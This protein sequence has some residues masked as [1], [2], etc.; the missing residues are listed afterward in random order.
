MLQMSQRDR[1]RLVVVR[2]VAMKQIAVTRGAELLRLSRKQMGRLRDRYVEEGDG[3]V[4]HR[5][6]GRRSNRAKPEVWRRRVLERAAE[7]IFHDF[8]PTL[9]AEHLSRDPEIGPVDPCTLR[10]WMIEEGL[11]TVKRRGERHR[12]SRPRRA[13]VGEL[14][15]WDSSDHA[16]LEDRYSGRLTLVTMIDDASSRLQY[17]RFVEQDNGQVNREAVIAYLEDHGRPVAFYA[18]QAGHFIQQT[19]SADRGPM[20]QREA[21][22]TESIIRR[23]LEELNVELIRARSPQAKGRVERDF[24]TAQDRLIKEMRVEGITTLDEANRYLESDWIPFWNERFAVEPAEGK[25]R[26]RPLPKRARLETLFAEIWTRVVTSDFTFR[27]KNRRYQIQKEQARGIR[28]KDRITIE[29]RVDGSAHFRWKGRYL[30]P[31][32]IAE[33]DA[34][35]VHVKGRA[36][37]KGSAPRVNGNRPEAPKARAANKKTRS[38]R[39][40]PDHPWRNSRIGR[41][42]RDHIPG[43]VK[44]TST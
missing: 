38:P 22:L 24:G 15:Q 32:L 13:A 8:R 29:L 4:I 1:D 30:T 14:V 36:P 18:D 7:P 2:Q 44:V 37:L 16:W 11:W 25:D 31:E 9:R 35:P 34:Q 6:R 40:A 12:R 43:K 19:R 27:F 39:P 41:G 26:H 17:A 23:G 20:E 10:R 5:G 28:P 33:Y 3:A 42:P 21:Q